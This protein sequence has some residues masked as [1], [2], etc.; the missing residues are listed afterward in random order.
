MP[1]VIWKRLTLS[2]VD[3]LWIRQPVW[4]K[5]RNI[6]L[7]QFFIY[8][9]IIDWTHICIINVLASSSFN[10]HPREKN[11]KLWFSWFLILIHNFSLHGNYTQCTLINSCVQLH[12]IYGL[13]YSKLKCRLANLQTIGE[14]LSLLNKSTGRLIVASLYFSH[15][16]LRQWSLQEAGKHLW[17]PFQQNTPRALNLSRIRLQNIVV[18]LVHSLCSELKCAIQRMNDGKNFKVILSICCWRDLSLIE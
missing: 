5:M 10:G 13:V 8:I 17:F 18:C 3:W 7:P 6:I 1:P 12:S 14:F 2:N 16:L 4:L 15:L 11:L 9:H